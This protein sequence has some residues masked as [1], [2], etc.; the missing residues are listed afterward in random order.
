MKLAVEVL[1]QT[2]LPIDGGHFA[3]FTNSAEFAAALR[4]HVKPLIR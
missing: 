2:G 1:E 3:C 4:E